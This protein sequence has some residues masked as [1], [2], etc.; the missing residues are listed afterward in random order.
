MQ[1]IIYYDTKKKVC[2]E[3]CTFLTINRMFYEENVISLNGIKSLIGLPFLQMLY[4]LLK[5][6]DYKVIINALIL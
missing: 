6:H 4:L 5:L 2:I 3:M 1:E